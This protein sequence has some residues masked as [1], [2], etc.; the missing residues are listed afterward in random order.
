V[1]VGCAQKLVIQ[2]GNL[3]GGYLE[4]HASVL[5]GRLSLRLTVMLSNDATLRYF[6]SKND[7]LIR[8]IQN[9][10]RTNVNMIQE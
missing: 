9:D 8:G 7:T 3:K 2:S 6:A 4:P 5:G 10:V 1:V